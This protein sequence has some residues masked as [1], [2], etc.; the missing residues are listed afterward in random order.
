MRWLLVAVAVLGAGCNAAFGLDGTEQL[1]PPDAPPP[2]DPRVDEDLDGVANEA[3]NCPGVANPEQT[4]LS[5]G[6][7]PDSVGDAC[8][9][10]ELGQDRIVARYYFNDPADA[11]AWMADAAF[12]F[13]DGHVEI[14]P[15]PELAYMHALQLPVVTRGELT[16]E[17]GFELLDRA[18]GTRV[19]V[20]ADGPEVHYGYVELRPETYLV[21]NNTFPASPLCTDIRTCDV[22][23]IPALPDRAVVQV[24]SGDGNPKLDGI[25]VILA[26]TGVDATFNSTGMTDNRAGVVAAAHARL[27]HVI[28][29]EGD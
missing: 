17:A 26:G 18:A 29:Y 13:A 3:D 11:A 7:T 21:I 14:A 8:D 25:K 1:I 20:Y 24:R 10:D 5:E 23:I 27:L 9:P 16:I 22:E 6:A 15:T 19:G 4:N 28:V 2:R 12:T